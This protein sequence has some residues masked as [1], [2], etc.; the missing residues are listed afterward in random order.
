MAKKS[1][2]VVAYSYS[3][4]GNDGKVS[5]TRLFFAD[6]SELLLVGHV[7][8]PVLA[9]LGFQ[10]KRNEAGLFE[11]KGVDLLAG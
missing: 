4:E 10:Y 8:L 3:Y 6:G 5:S 2:R 7:H 11:L 9:T 1:G